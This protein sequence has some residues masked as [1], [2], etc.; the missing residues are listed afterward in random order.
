MAAIRVSYA[1]LSLSADRERDP[2]EFQ[3]ILGDILRKAEVSFVSCH[4]FFLE[5]NLR[6]RYVR[7]LSL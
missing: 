2:C 5:T 7:L 4:V 6:F 3:D 1:A